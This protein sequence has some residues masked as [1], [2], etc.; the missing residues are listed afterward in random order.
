[1]RTVTD[2]SFPKDDY[3]IAVRKDDPELLAKIHKGLADM[4]ADGSFAAISA[5]YVGK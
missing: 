3:G 4:K 2:P 1:M 5:Q